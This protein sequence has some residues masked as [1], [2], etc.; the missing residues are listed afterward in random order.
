MFKA[1]RI[2]IAIF[3]VLVLF[4]T[5]CRKTA[6]IGGNS[7]IQGK[8]K[9]IYYDVFGNAYPYYAGKV[10][11]YIIYG[12][13]EYFGDDVETSYDGTY[14]FRYLRKGQ[15]TIF[16]Y[17]DC[18]TCLGKKRVEMIKTEITKNN[19]VVKLED[20]VIVKK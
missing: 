6:G 4:I 5:G 18:D 17:S 14:E 3:S 11:V 15:Y 19:S 12:D 10:D 8:V 7:T 1:L 2:G 20:L 16:A 9:A 13:E